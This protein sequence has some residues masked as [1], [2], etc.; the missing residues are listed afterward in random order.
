[1]EPEIERTFVHNSGQV[2]IDALFVGRRKG[3]N[4][5]FVVEAKTES[6]SS[7][8]KFKLVYPVL[9][10]MNRIPKEMPIVPVFVHIAQRADGILYQVAECSFD[11]PRETMAVMTELETVRTAEYLLPLERRRNG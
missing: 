1:M 2:E 11:D 5:L 4:V 7:V 9:S 10:L 6:V 3:E 8:G